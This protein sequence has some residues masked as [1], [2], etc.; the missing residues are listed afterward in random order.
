MNDML[1]ISRPLLEDQAPSCAWLLDSARTILWVSLPEVEVIL[2]A[3]RAEPTPE[4]FL[5]AEEALQRELANIGAHLLASVVGSLHR[6]PRFVAEGLATA[7]A[8]QSQKLRNRG[9]RTTPVRFL[10]GVEIPFTTPY[11]SRDLEGRP[12]PRRGVGRRGKAGEGCYPV[13]EA[14]GIHENATPALTSAV[15]RECVRCVSF[16]E[17]SEALRERG[18]EMDAKTARS[19]ALSFG[20]RALRERQARQ[21]TAREGMTFSDEFAGERIVISTDGGR[22]RTREGGR[23]GRR[24]KK[25]RR[26]Y[27]TPW[28]EPKIVVAYVIDSRG[29]KKRGTRPIY[30]GT[31]E[32]ADAAFDLLTAELLLRGAAKAKEIIVTGDGAVWIWNRVDTLAR[33]LGF[34]PEKIVRVADFYHAVEHLTAIANLR[35]S[36]PEGNRKRWVSTMRRRLKR[37]KIDLVIKECRPLCRGR[38]ARRIA[39]EVAYF[40]ERRDFMRYDEYQKRGIPLGS[41][42]VES[43]VRR[44]VNLRLKGPA[45]FWSRSSAEAMLHLRAYLKAGR[46]EEVVHRVMHRSPD[47]RAR[48]P[49]KAVA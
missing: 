13:L 41:G 33:A 24:G 4:T 8:T 39:K 42:A 40:E 11:L 27:R 15:A 28:R 10:G 5:R 37:G 25:G 45:I 18:I 47:G 38:N 30:D 48:E 9:L 26:R 44:V 14:L 6:D 19:V 36:W 43:A 2:D 21:R 32:D 46:W 22:L 3:F 12:G 23:S 1:S 16:E 35:P 17:A 7:R 20:E 34:P 29:R 49:R 31:L